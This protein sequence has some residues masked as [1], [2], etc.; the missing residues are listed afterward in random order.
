MANVKF[1]QNGNRALAIQNS[2]G[3]T[4]LP[5]TGVALADSNPIHVAIVDGNGDQIATFGSATNPSNFVSGVATAT[6]T[7]STSLIAAPAASLRNYIT[8]ITV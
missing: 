3:D 1:D 6:D 7:T 8:Q 4:L 5:A 2:A